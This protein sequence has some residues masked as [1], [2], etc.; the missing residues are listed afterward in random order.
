MKE[1]QKH[2]IIAFA[3]GLCHRLSLNGREMIK[4]FR[5]LLSHKPPQPTHIDLVSAADL[6]AVWLK[7]NFE[8]EEKSS[9]PV[10]LTIVH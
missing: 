10:I 4:S 3:P 1:F 7:T 6:G 2:T 5:H 8:E 9:I